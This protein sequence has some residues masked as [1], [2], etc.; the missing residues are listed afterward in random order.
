MF[1]S[2]PGMGDKHT[3]EEDF[4]LA[5]YSKEQ[6]RI[7]KMIVEEQKQQGKL[8]HLLKP[9]KPVTLE[10][11]SD[12]DHDSD[13]DSESDPEVDDYYFLQPVPIRQRRVLLRQSGVKKIDGQEKEECKT[14]R[15][16]REV[17]GCDCKVFC[18]PA[19]CACSLAGI[20]CQVDRL[21]F[22]CGCTKDGCGNHAGRIEFNPI[23]VRTHFI[24]TLMRLELERKDAETKALKAQRQCLQ[25]GTAQTQK[26]EQAKELVATEENTDEDQWEY[27]SNEK[28]SCRDCQNSEVCHVMMQEAQAQYARTLENE[29]RCLPPQ[30]QQHFT[31]D[32]H[33]VGL[34]N[35]A[36]QA[37]SLASPLPRV[38]LFSD[39]EEE[40]YTADNTTSIFHF[41]QEESSYSESSDCSS[42]NSIDNSNNYNKSYQSLSTFDSSTTANGSAA[43]FCEDGGSVAQSEP[44][45]YIDLNNSP[46]PGM[47]KLEP[48]AGVLNGVRP[49]E[50]AESVQSAVLPAWPENGE[51]ANYAA[52]SKAYPQP[53]MSHPSQPPFSYT[54]MTDTT[55][56]QLAEKCPGISTHMKNQNL[57]KDVNGELAPFTPGSTGSLHSDADVLCGGSLDGFP[58]S[59]PQTTENTCSGIGSDSSRSPVYTEVNGNPLGVAENDSPDLSKSLFNFDKSDN[60]LQTA[61]SVDLKNV[62]LSGNLGIEFA[63][64][65]SVAHNTDS[66]SQANFTSASLKPIDGKPNFGELIKESLVE[67]AIA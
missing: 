18:D 48:M 16:S 65:I 36:P 1:V 32:L 40:F 23:R 6:K 8:V 12:S 47:F 2:F 67:T 63:S 55:S 34:Q 30:Q 60:H 5:E 58:L 14:I 66:D 31:P 15:T 22:P 56:D 10:E 64:E 3:F 13:S 33:G 59:P 57:S 54:T 37:S 45:K 4:T 28:G 21:S 39:N 42:E 11:K 19:T 41:K 51:S 24:H 52:C 49:S 61:T 25:N 35:I 46:A 20:K 53:A 44:Q 9:T 38:L 26:E 62:A 7:H 43:N 50:F 27:N 29:Q 17:C